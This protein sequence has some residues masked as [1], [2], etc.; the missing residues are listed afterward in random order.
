MISTVLGEIPANELGVTLMHEHIAWDW[1][2]A[3]SANVYNVDEVVNTILPYLLDLKI[4]GCNTFVEATTYGAGRSI[5]ILRE[6]AKKSGLNILT[7]VGAW[8]GGD[9]SGKY[10]PGFI[11][12]KGIDYIVEKWTAEY[13]NGI[14]DTRVKPAFIKIAL[15]DTGVITQIQEKILRAAI[16]TSLKTNLPIQCHTLSAD[17]ASQ[18]ISIAEE[19][20]LYLEKFIW[21]HADWEKN[22]AII[23][24]L[25]EKGIWVEFDC[26]AR[27]RDF[28]WYFQAIKRIAEEGFANKLL[29]SQDAGAFYY[30]RKNDESSI[31]PYSRIFKEFT[32]LCRDH[33]LTQELLNIVL[34]INPA[35]V[36]DIS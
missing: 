4:Y 1:E 31:L 19:E 15:G 27:A 6:C 36:L 22:W 21:V 14:G 29:L 32:P 10:I 11:K 2:G 13:L 34:R 8:D 7:N 18:A 9:C 5:E 25:L 24:Q 16:R 35:K 26:L 17:S 23:N 28:S 12:E 20:K 30:G 33:G 3:E